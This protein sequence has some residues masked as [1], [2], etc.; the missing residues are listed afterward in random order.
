LEPDRESANE[1]SVVYE[2]NR[3]QVQHFSGSRCRALELPDG[4]L[5]RYN[6][7]EALYFYLRTAIKDG[8][9]N[10]RVFA[11]DSPYDREKASIG[12]VT[13]PIFESHAEAMH[14]KKVE[15][16]IRSWIDFV[17]EP[18]E[19]VEFKSFSLDEQPD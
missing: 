6:L 18:E 3:A 4:V 10:T 9:I 13:T 16:L 17:G 11:T 19:S 7:F 2:V 15:R 14:L 1:E 12:E 5:L 8:K